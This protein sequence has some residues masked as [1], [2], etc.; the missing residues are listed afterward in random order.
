L[1]EGT[2]EEKNLIDF[3][4]NCLNCCVEISGGAMIF[5]EPGQK[6]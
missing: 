6:L 4:I 2:Y 3:D 5:I 1:T